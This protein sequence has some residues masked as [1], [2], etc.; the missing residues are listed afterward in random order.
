MENK[1]FANF[2]IHLASIAG[3]VLKKYWGKLTRIEE[4]T[5]AGDLVTEADKESERLIIAE[6]QNEFPAHSILGEESGAVGNQDAEFLWI[7]DPLDGTTNYSHQYPFFAVSIGLVRRNNPIAGVVYNPIYNELFVAAKGRGATLN[8]YP[9]KVSTVN[10]LSQ[11]LLATGFPYNRRETKD[12]NYAEFFHLTS[13]TQGVRR[14]GSAA[15][16]L[17][18]VACGRLDGFW[19]QGL[20]PWDSA[21]GVLLVEEA[22]GKVTNYQGE[23]FDVYSNYILATNSRIHDALVSELIL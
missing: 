16:D 23:P 10:S 18:N 19:E 6:I 12:N 8:H 4:K 5:H 3:E 21:A 11:S 17:A 22:G 13:V 1:D 2:A 7:I 9:I 15:L 20:K 14:Q